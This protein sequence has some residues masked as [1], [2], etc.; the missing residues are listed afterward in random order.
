M[1]TVPWTVITLLAVTNPA[2][3]QKHFRW[4][5]VDG[6]S[7]SVR[8]V[9]DITQ[10][11]AIAEQTIEIPAK[12]TMNLTWQV[13]SVADDGTAEVVQTVE[14]V[15]MNLTIPG[16]DDDVEFD[17]KSK[18]EPT[19]ILAPI[20]KVIKPLIGVEFRQQM[21]ASGRVLKVT[22]PQ[23]TFKGLES[24][25]TLKQFFSGE[26]FKQMI[27]KASPVFPAEAIEQG[28]T[29]KNNVT[30]K[31]PLGS[32]TLDATYTYGGEQD[33]N[34]QTL[35][36]FSVKLTMAIEADDNSRGT[37][38]EIKDQ[39]IKGTMLFDQS[40]GFLT[41]STLQQTISMKVTSGD[42]VVDQTVKNTMTMTVVKK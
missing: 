34:D 19:A 41:E 12:I 39:D 3:A 30:Q 8:V 11:V 24:D 13:D 42:T 36:K 40:E 16:V 22:V 35:D 23:E 31:T 38:V 32:A 18:E 28:H 21:D 33:T 20:A 14:Q 17:S 9:Q 29:W 25:P 37:K 6:D 4:K 1:K 27:T 10:T 2:Q 7:Y 26:S 5:F 15:T